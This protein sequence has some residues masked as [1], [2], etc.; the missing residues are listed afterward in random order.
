MALPFERAIKPGKYIQETI[1]SSI[2]IYIDSSTPMSFTLARRVRLRQQAQPPGQRVI[3]PSSRRTDSLVQVPQLARAQRHGLVG[4]RAD[5]LS[6][7]DTLGPRGTAKRDVV[8]ARKRVRF[9][10]RQPRPRAR[11]GRGGPGAE[12]ALAVGA[13]GLDDQ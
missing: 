12:V 3:I 4:V 2:Y 11:Q 7:A 13:D 8:A 6:V 9:C 10:V 1:E 5:G